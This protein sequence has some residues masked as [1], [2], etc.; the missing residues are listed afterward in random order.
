MCP[1]TIQEMK[2]VVKRQIMPEPK[3]WYIPFHD[4]LIALASQLQVPD[5]CLQVS[6]G[7]EITIWTA[8]A[9]QSVWISD[10]EGIAVVPIRSSETATSQA[11]DPWV[12]SRFRAI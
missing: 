8:R 9:Q 3:T 1:I 11:D 4:H 5:L 12:D 10:A 7:T 6:Q 2:T